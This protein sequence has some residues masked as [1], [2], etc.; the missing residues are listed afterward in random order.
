MDRQDMT[1]YRL[2]AARDMEFVQAL[3][4]DLYIEGVLAVDTETLRQRIYARLGFSALGYLGKAITEAEIFQLI[5]GAGPGTYNVVNQLMA[6]GGTDIRDALKTGTISPSHMRG[7]RASAL[8]R[9]NGNGNG[10][11]S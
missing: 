5:A 1:R 6:M 3:Y 7:I 11:S 4:N 10:V 2:N 8:P 9:S